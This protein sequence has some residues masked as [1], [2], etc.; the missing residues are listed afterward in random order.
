MV[1]LQATAKTTPLENVIRLI[2]NKSLKRLIWEEGNVRFLIRQ[3]LLV[4]TRVQAHL[5]HF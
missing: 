5:K 2:L 1:T 4:K 3:N